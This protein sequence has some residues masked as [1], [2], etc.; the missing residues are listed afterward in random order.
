M[1]VLDRN[2]WWLTDLF[3]LLL[4]LLCLKNVLNVSIRLSSFVSLLNI[5]PVF[6]GI[7][8]CVKFRERLLVSMF[9]SMKS[10]SDVISFLNKAVFDLHGVEVLGVIINKIQQ[11]KYENV[12]WKRHWC[13]FN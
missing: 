11:D 2:W 12:L 8:D 7:F 5:S 13:K 1:F 4:L 3:S 10:S 6:L 9:A